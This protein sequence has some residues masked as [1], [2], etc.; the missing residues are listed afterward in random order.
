MS[1][2]QIIFNRLYHSQI[3]NIWR[4]LLT[5]DS[6]K[7]FTIMAKKKINWGIIGLGNIAR[8]FAHDLQLVDEA[9]I[10]GVASRNEEKAKAFA[11]EFDASRFYGS[12]EALAADRAIDVVYVATPHPMHFE[13]SMLCL[14]HGKHV[15][16]EK[17]LGM[18][19][20]E[21]KTLLEEA[22][23]RKL[24]LMEGIWTR[25]IPGTIKVLQLI[26]EG[27]IGDIVSLQADFGFKGEYNPTS[28][29]FSKELGGGS[30][31]DIGIYTVYLSLLLLGMPSD[32]KAMARM[33]P[34]GVDG[35]CAML[36]D[37][38]NKAKAVLQSSFETNTPIE[39]AIYGSLG[40]LKMHSR[41]HH[42]RKISLCR[43]GAP[44]KTIDIDYRGNG[45]VHEIEEV[46]RCLNNHWHESPLLPL[47][48][49]LDLTSILDGVKEAIGLR[50]D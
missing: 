14:Q 36:F 37:Y 16:C 7:T 39:A 31:L 47:Q 43:Q 23:K 9:I 19:A 11:R 13:I 2:I 35:F 3:I 6:S 38:P 29:L 18:N 25:F 49:S 34:T 10:C 24:F 45:Y 26:E 32:I 41:F 20:F 50:Y 12:Y 17:P 30:L 42:T 33:A 4:Y 8:T 15:L 22:R 5:N 21:V 48:T 40:S 46:H 27:A 44:E 1:P 28:R